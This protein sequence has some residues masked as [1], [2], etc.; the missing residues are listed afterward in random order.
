MDNNCE[1]FKLYPILKYLKKDDVIPLAEV[2]FYLQ[3]YV[4]CN[5]DK[6]TLD[7]VFQLN[8][9]DMR[10]SIDRASYS[11]PISKNK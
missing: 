3:P 4:S 2:L 10:R 8:R 1:V 11:H 7:A 9:E 6:P 5:I